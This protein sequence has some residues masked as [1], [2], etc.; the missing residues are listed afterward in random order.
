MNT[1]TPKLALPSLFVSRRRAILG[2]I[3][4]LALATVFAAVVTTL[5]A[6]EPDPNPEP[7]ATMADNF[8]Q[9]SSQNQA[10]IL[11]EV[12]GDLD[13]DGSDI[14]V[15][16]PLPVPPDG[17]A[18]GA[19][20]AADHYDDWAS[21][22]NAAGVGGHEN[23]GRQGAF[24][25]DPHSKVATDPNVFARGGK[26]FDID[27]WNIEA[28]KVGAQAN[29]LVNVAVYKVDKAADG[30]PWL[31]IALERTKE[32]G[33]F[34]LWAEFNRRTDGV[35]GTAWKMINGSFVPDRTAGDVAVGFEL[36]GNPTGAAHLE[37]VIIMWDDDLT[38]AV[39][40]T[41]ANNVDPVRRGNKV[42]GYEPFDPAG[43]NLGGAPPLFAGDWYYLFK[44]PG[45]FLGGLGA[46]WM[47]LFPVDPSGV[48]D[49]V[50]WQSINAQGAPRALIP[51]FQFA[52]AALNLGAGGLN[53][54]PNC[55]GFGSVHAVSVASLSP[56]SDAKDVTAP[57][58]LTVSCDTDLSVR[59]DHVGDTTLVNDSITFTITEQNLGDVPL[60]SPE[61][62]VYVNLVEDV[63]Q[64][65]DAGDINGAADGDTNDNDILD[66][67]ETWVWTLTTPALAS[68]ND[69]DV[70]TFYA[71]GIAQVGSVDFDVTHDDALNNPRIGTT[72]FNDTDESA[73]ITIAVIDPSTMIDVQT[74][75]AAGGVFGDAELQFLDT[76]TVYFRITET[77]DGD[78]ALTEVDV[79]LVG[80]AHGPVLLTRQSDNPGNNDA[81]L[82][83]SEVWV[84]TG[85]VA[86]SGDETFTANGAG[87]DPLGTVIDAAFDPQGRRRHPHR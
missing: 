12:D 71:H 65:L 48:S 79:A 77:N 14:E 26:F 63:A 59:S 57:Q 23:G 66:V 2:L 15:P 43:G 25:S 52:E 9:S 75:R 67:G 53:I 30:N 11:F 83:V 68:I 33:T 55:E 56:T 64:R 42:V 32:N 27:T 74:A 80:D 51:E 7:D 38:D 84:Y 50:V 45:G 8:Q 72:G 58:P 16:A 41:A 22:I 40:I 54:N 85:A 47:N 31:A 13:D 78:V 10:G 19:L 34:A 28:G 86:V 49:G 87:L 35:N 39:G 3:A 60:T 76:D 6:V 44:G 5:S 21:V 61:V 29:E 24:L 36:S 70:Y 4:L 37:L 81:V 62:D 17:T 73:S 69:G 20:P 1:Q 46:G 18:F 82:D